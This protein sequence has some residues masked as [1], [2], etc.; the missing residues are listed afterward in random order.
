MKYI[1]SSKEWNWKCACLQ[2]RRKS[3]GKWICQFYY[4]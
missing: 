3:V 2:I 4:I 1:I